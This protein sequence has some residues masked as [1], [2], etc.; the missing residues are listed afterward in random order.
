MWFQE[1][2]DGLYALFQRLLVG[3]DF[4]RRVG[5]WLIGGINASE[6]FNLAGSCFFIKP[7]DIPGFADFQWCIDVNFEEVFVPDNLPGHVSYFHR[8][9]DEGIQRD[10]AAVEVQ[11][12]DFRN[13]ADIF[14]PVFRAETE[15]V[16]NAAADVV[17]IEHLRKETIIIK[18]AFQML[19]NRA[20]ARAGQ[21]GKPQDFT[22]LAKPLLPVAAL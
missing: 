18:V 11:P 8:W 12:G 2:E 19:S 9:A 16:I 22:P 7:F 20:F 10:N 3:F 5:R 14:L 21:A 4:Q 6:A 17:A 1:L 13:A 15:V